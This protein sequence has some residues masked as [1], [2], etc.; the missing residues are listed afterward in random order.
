MRSFRWMSPKRYF[1]S[2]RPLLCTNQLQPPANHS[3]AAVSLQPIT[4]CL[5]LQVIAVVNR[6]PRSI[7]PSIQT[8]RFV[9]LV[10][11]GWAAVTFADGL[12]QQLQ[13]QI[14][15]HQTLCKYIWVFHRYH[16]TTW[17]HENWAKQSPTKVDKISG[18]TRCHRASVQ[19]PISPYG[20][21]LTTGRHKHFS[22]CDAFLFK[23]KK[24][25]KVSTAS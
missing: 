6:T 17:V 24:C 3:S 11:I 1:S 23:K 12:R 4:T 19:F 22:S 25:S 5:P 15:T 8:R 20:V 18:F 10:L 2:I 9:W 14:P 16:I 7:C 13:R 21:L